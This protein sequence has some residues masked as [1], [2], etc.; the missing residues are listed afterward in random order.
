MKSWLRQGRRG[1]LLALPLLLAG[2]ATDGHNW[3]NVDNCSAIKPGAIPVPSGTYLNEWME[4][5]AAKAEADDFVIY[6]HEW[7]QGG[8]ELGPYGRYHIREM[9][10]RLPD[11]PFVVVVQADLNEELNES[12]RQVIVQLLTMCGV[13]NVEPRVMVAFPQAEG[14]DGREASRIY[15]EMVR[16][17]STAGGQSPQTLGGFGTGAFGAGFGGFG[18]GFGMGGIR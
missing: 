9:A 5:Q 14:L 8:V 10:K 4:T 3:W 17:G 18:G 7:L 1:W 12:R 13:P 11:V 16:E 15:Q 2:C 6:K